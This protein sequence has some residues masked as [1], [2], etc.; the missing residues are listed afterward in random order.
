MSV[1][2]AL[3]GQRHCNEQKEAAHVCA[4]SPRIDARNGSVHL[5]HAAQAR[6]RRGCGPGLYGAGQCFAPATY[7]R[8]G[9]CPAVMCARYYSGAALLEPASEL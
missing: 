5:V 8:A 9:L 4:F 6:V 7:K 1:L 2:L 3:G